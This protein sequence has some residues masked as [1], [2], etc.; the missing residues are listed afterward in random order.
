MD[1]AGTPTAS[2]ET[3]HTNMIRL[4]A[5]DLFIDTIAPTVWQAALDYRLDPVGVVAQSAHETGWASFPRKT[6]PWHRNTCGLKVADYK[7]LEQWGIDS[8]HPLA[9]AQF[10]TWQMGALAHVQHLW[11]YLGWPVPLR[12]LVDPRYH[13]IDQTR[14]VTTY[15]EL[16]GRWAGAGYG[17]RVVDV[18]A[19]LTEEV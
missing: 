6:Q 8:E 4:G 18:A 15:Q 7:L 17:A 13:H 14:R 3:V 2:W 10:A 19:R 5:T 16:G 9:H 1:I 11:A 12:D